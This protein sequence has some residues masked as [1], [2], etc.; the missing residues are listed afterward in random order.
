MKNAFL[1]KSFCVVVGFVFLVLYAPHL[2]ADESYDE[3]GNVI[4]LVAGDIQAIPVTGL[5]RVSVT[6]PEVADISD[7]QSDKVS[8]L[9]KKAGSTVLFLWDVAG[10]HSVRIRV[11]NEDLSSIKARVQKLLD[12]ANITGVTLDEN[13]DEGK[14]VMEGA[15][16]KEDKNRLEDV[17]QP[18]S[19]NLL[20]LVKVDKNEDLIQVDMQVVEINTTFEQD[21]G[22]SWGAGTTN[23]SINT[24]ST[25]ITNPNG[26]NGGTALS[27]TSSGAGL[28]LPYT[29][30]PPG[31]NGKIGDFFKIGSFNRTF[32][33]QAQ[34]NALLQE[35][36]AKLISKPRLV[37][38][39]GKQASFLV[40][41]EIPIQN[42]TTTASGGT[43]NTSTSYTQY[44][45]NMTV[46]PTIHNGKID[47]VL[48]IDI[49]DVDNSSSFSTTSS[50][51]FITRT[52]STDLLMDDK[53]TIALAGFIKHSESET[54]NEVPFLSKVPLLGALFRNRNIPGDS[55]TEMVVILTPTVLT[56]RNIS[57]KQLVMPTPSERETYKQFDSKYE[58]EPLPTWP[59][60][61]VVPSAP[62]K[63]EVMSEMTA[64]AR[65]VQVKISRSITYP[66]LARAKSLGGTV[67]LRL[68]IL[69][70]GSLDSAEVTESSG[71]VILDQDAVHAAKIAAPYDVFTTGMSQDDLIF[72]IPIVYNKLIAG[73]TAPAEKVI[74]SY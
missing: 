14:V 45:V 59:V 29:E 62:Q 46:T 63:P 19:E 25:G 4:D 61:K 42:T 52:A 55:N 20:N 57:D 22:I 11:V 35:G 34:V 36:K 69:K 24:T 17:V 5:S 67:K 39:N 60:P 64:Y 40:G 74:A 32:Q 66:Q 41:G 44:G 30:K 71:V 6:N 28:S 72:T 53:Q 27:A 70:N 13:L 31:T 51:A 18:Y 9:A 21:L 47:V 26:A 50:V 48:N 73:A 58:H 49:R 2:S 1:K 7:A 65:S 23:G 33:L 43:Q 3:T 68:H 15:L 37:V 10:K 56:D 54:L 38:V 12:E 16:L 8:L